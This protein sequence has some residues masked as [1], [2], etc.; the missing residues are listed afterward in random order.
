MKSV[1][2]DVDGILS[3]VVKE[4]EEEEMVEEKREREG[5]GRD[6]V[7]KAL[8]GR[9]AASTLLDRESRSVLGRSQF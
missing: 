8:G 1:E 2:E 3:V 9:W 4:R 5:R 6:G 7:E